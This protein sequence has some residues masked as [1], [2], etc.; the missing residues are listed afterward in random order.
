VQPH[1]LSGLD[2]FPMIPASSCFCVVPN[3]AK[4]KE[5]VYWTVVKHPPRPDLRIVQRH[6]LYLDELNCVQEPSWR[7]TVDLFFF[8]DEYAP[9]QGMPSVE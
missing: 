9:S 2:L 4:I 3:V 1:P 8:Q 7:K 5:H 6:V